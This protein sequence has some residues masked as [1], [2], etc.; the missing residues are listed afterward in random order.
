MAGNIFVS[1]M[2]NAHPPL[3]PRQ[4]GSTPAGLLHELH[5]SYLKLEHRRIAQYIQHANGCVD[6]RDL[7][8]IA[9]CASDE[10]SEEGNIPDVTPGVTAGH[11]LHKHHKRSSSS[12]AADQAH[13]NSF[14]V[15]I[16]GGSKIRFEV[17]LFGCSFG[18]FKTGYLV[19]LLIQSGTLASRRGR[20]G[21]TPEIAGFLLD[22]ATARGVCT[23]P[24]D[25]VLATPNFFPTPPP[26]ACHYRYSAKY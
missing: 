17:G 16:R 13:Q 5:Q 25:P 26:L 2:S 4:Q 7:V 18:A 19:H 1:N 14:E 10:I 8:G 22:S 15:M 3:P 6:L 23:S 21:F 12:S 11:K 20:V 9:L 24:F